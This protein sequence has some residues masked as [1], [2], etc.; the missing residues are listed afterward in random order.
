MAARRILI[1]DGHPDPARE[2][3]GHALADAYRR[4]AEAA[5]HAVRTVRVADHDFDCLR[6]ADEFEQ[7]EPPP[8]IANAARDLAWCDHIVL[9]FPL[10]MGGMPAHA[11]AFVE[12]LLRPGVALDYRDKAFPKP[13]LRGK[14]L[15]IIVTMGMPAFAYRWLFGAH[16]VKRLTRGAFGFSGVRPIRISL[17]GRIG[18]GGL[19]SH[20]RLIARVGRLGHSAR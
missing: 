20:D 9:L 17:F 13:L 14:S 8:F 10:W 18:A 5:G 15:R 7:G 4:Q 6:S 11:M 2:R 3:L 16:G 19:A 1:I 12:H